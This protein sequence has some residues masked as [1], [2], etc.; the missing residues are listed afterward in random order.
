MAKKIEKKKELDPRIK[1]IAKHIKYLRE[2]AGY[3]NYENFA[4]EHEIGRMQYWNIEKGSNIT[5]TT[6]FK[7]LD[8]HKLS[9][10]EFF[11]PI[12]QNQNS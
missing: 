11:T 1:E 10:A 4:W 3:T 6:L 7:I 2:K 5:L 9:M 8:A 12:T